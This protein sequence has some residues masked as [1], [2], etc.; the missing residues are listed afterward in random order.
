[1][2]R[3]RFAVVS[4]SAADR[5]GDRFREEVTAFVLNQ[6]SFDA[7]RTIVSYRE[8]H[9]YPLTRVTLGVA[10]M[11]KTANRDDKFRPGQR[12]K[13]LDRILA[14]LLRYPHMRLSQMED[15]G[16]CRVVLPSLDHVVAVRDRIISNWGDRA[17]ETDYIAEPKADGYRGI[18]IIEKRDGRLIEV[19]LRT[20]GQ[21]GWAT[22]IEEFSPIVGYDLKDGAG[23]DDLKEY[24]K[25]AADR[26]ARADAGDPLDGVLEEQM[27]MLREQVRPYFT[28]ET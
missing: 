5:A 28:R 6:S 26:I 18:H 13:R 10:S 7:L 14:K 17:H 27:N 11:V 21:H 15:I 24:F 3:R 20:Q 25:V 2:P 8:M 23:P 16:G 19:Q 4:N 22:A 12:F 1:M 9:S